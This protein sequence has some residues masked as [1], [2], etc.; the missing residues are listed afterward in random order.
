MRRKRDVD[1]IQAGLRIDRAV[2]IPGEDL[3][4]KVSGVQVQP[5]AT[6]TELGKGQFAEGLGGDAEWFIRLQPN[7][8]QVCS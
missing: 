3:E 7:P 1:H 4:W 2:K 6:Q 5:E 8:K